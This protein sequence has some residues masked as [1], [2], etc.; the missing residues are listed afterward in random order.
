MP[1]E[2]PA[3]YRLRI[4]VALIA[5]AMMAAPLWVGRFLPLLDLP[6]HLAITTVLLHHDDPTW[7]LAAYFEPQRGELTPYW[8]HYLALEWLG[9][10]MPVDSAARVFL[11]LY[12]V[13]LPWASM[14]LA[15]ALG[16]PPALGLFAIPLALNANLYYGFIAYC[17]SVV[18]LLWALALLARQLDSPRAT[19]AAGLGVIAG[20]LFFTHVQSFA[21]LLLAAAV[22]IV[23]GGAAPH[24]PE[25]PRALRQRDPG[26]RAAVALGRSAAIWTRALRAWPLAPAMLILFLPWLYLS[27]TSRPGAERY[28]APLDDPRAKF[29]APLRRL[30]GLPSAVAGSYQ[31]G[32]DDWLLAAWAVALAAAAVAARPDTHVAA[33][34][35]DPSAAGSGPDGPPARGGVALT[36]AAL[37]CYFAL[38]LSIQG[39]WNI[40]PR[41]AWTASLI[42]PCLLRRPPRWLPAATLAL[43]AATAANA[44]WHHARFDREAGAIDR[45]LAALPRGARV[46]GL[47]YDSRGDVLERWP[48][49]HFEQYAV[50]R[51]GGM[52]AHSFTANAP[53]PVRLR[54]EARVSAPGVW[55]PD[56]FRYDVH[57][58]FF[59]H[60][61]VRDPTGR[62][63][64]SWP[65]ARAMEEVFREGA[66]RVYRGRSDI[67]RINGG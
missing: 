25:P 26:S 17:W 27:T 42:L 14:A 19:R 43:A 38:P 51:G 67:K 36:V 57:G 56:E 5:S 52:A 15:R 20:A 29:E 55:R 31:D 60:F 40:A 53:L 63:D 18:V 21:F 59:D 48:Y 33:R 61:L 44:A 13:A 32:T 7:Q 66:W 45:G 54:T 64:V 35:P 30:A 46:L 47:I 3:D 34:G 2:H 11:S 62:H 4:A 50:V 28:F 49:L 24:P 9:R 37:A 23:R 16:R 22:L 10:V 39:Q 58:A 41:F 65:D 12:V 8:A 6:Q 1:A